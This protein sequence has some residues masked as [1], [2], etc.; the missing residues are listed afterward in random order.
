MPLFFQQQVNTHTG[1]AIWKIEEDEGF[2]E[3]PLQRTITHPHKRLQHLA[4]RYLLKHL[5]PHF[6]LALIQL[7]DTKK[8]YLENELFHFSISH[9][10]DF[11]AVIVSTHNR[12]GID[13]ELVSEK[14]G[15]IQNKFVSQAEM[16]LFKTLWTA[17]AGV[18][19]NGDLPSPLYHQLTLIWSCKEAVFKWYGLG[20]VDFKKHMLLQHVETGDG[21]LFLTTM[22]FQKEGPQPIQLQSRFFENLCL[23]YVVT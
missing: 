17:G 15:R 3:V 13:V 19:Q 2:F 10:G 12:V 11:A 20:E 16:E 7:A 23:S 22:L 8:P 21:K 6:P 14:T 9:C 18:N 5:V 1:L 4:G